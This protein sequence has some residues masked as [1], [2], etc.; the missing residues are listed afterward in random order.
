M[1]DATGFEAYALWNSLKL[2]F[3]SD[4]YDYIKYHGKTNVSKQ[5]FMQN[6]FKWHFTKLSRKYNKEELKNFYISNFIEGKGEYV[7][8]LLQDGAENY[9]KW[10][11][12]M[13][14]LSYNF[15]NDVEFLLGAYE[16][17]REMPFKV[18]SGQH[19]DLLG[20]MLRGKITLE[21]VCILDDILNFLPRW[22]KEIDDDIVWPAHY[23]LISKYKPLIEYDKQKYKNF[24]KEKINGHKYVHENV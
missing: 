14:S 11:K 7:I 12:R 19:P 23:R 1:T 17:D 16:D 3:T 8:E 4:S 2:H 6:K 18:F 15:K 5:S 22:K 24:L 10:M 21:T 9:A 20:L 13:Q